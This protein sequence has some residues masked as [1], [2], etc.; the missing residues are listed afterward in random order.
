M[1]TMMAKRNMYQAIN[2]TQGTIGCTY[3]WYL[4]CSL[5]ILGDYKPFSYTLY[6]AHIGIFPEGYIR[7]TPL[8]FPCG[9]GK[10]TG[11]FD[12]PSSSASLMKNGRNA[13]QVVCELGKDTFPCPIPSMYRIFT[14]IYHKFMV[15]VGQICHTWMV[16]VCDIVEGFLL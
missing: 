1:F 11:R 6:R 8:I 14:C 15:N 16:W 9:A 5:G 4:L 13:F 2:L 7:R 10:P 3:S 12:T